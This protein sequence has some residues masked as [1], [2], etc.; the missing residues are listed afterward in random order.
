M[1]AFARA[2]ASAARAA[3]SSRGYSGVTKTTLL[4]VASSRAVLAREARGEQVLA[5]CHLGHRPLERAVDGGRRGGDHGLAEVRELRTE[6]VVE[7]QRDAR[8]HGCGEGGALGQ[9]RTRA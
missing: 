5:L 3:S 9:A 2:G 8:A 7:R 6:H 1:A 4:R